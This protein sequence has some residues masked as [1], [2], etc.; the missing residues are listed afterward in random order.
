MQVVVKIADLDNSTTSTSV[1]C[2]RV[3]TTQPQLGKKTKS[4]LIAI[5]QNP[6]NNTTP[7]FAM[8]KKKDMRTLKF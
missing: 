2:Y 4:I 6:L 3:S 5:F 8:G 7:S 1:C